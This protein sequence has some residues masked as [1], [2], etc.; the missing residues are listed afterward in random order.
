MLIKFNCKNVDFIKW[1]LLLTKRL[2]CVFSGKLDLRLLFS[3][4]A[5]LVGTNYVMIFMQVSG[6]PNMFILFIIVNYLRTVLDRVNIL[7]DEHF[8]VIYF[9]IFL[10]L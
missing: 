5:M 9:E 8:I 6:D 2:A 1:Y 10:L 4:Y 3:G 7:F